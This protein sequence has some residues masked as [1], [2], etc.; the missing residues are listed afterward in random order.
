MEPPSADSPVPL[1]GNRSHPSLPPPDA[2]T[3]PP[4]PHPQPRTRYL[5]VRAAA[6]RRVLA[7]AIAAGVIFDIACHSG[8]TSIAGAAWVSVVAVVTLCSRRTR[9][10]TA[11]LFI[12]AAPAFGLILAVRASPWVTVPTA[13]A[14]GL[15]LTL[16]V[17]LGADNAGLTMTFPAL[18]SR[19][20]VAIGHFGL[21]PGF[22]RPRADIR[23]GGSTGNGAAIAKGLL[24]AAPVLL[25]VGLLL[26]EADPIFRSWFDLPS[27][28]H[29]LVLAAAGAWVAAGLARAASAERAAPA[30]PAAPSLG[31][32]EAALVLG[33]LCALYAVFVAAQ[34]V[35]LSGAGH[36]ILVTHGLTYAQYARSGFFELL[37]CAAITLPVL[38]GVRACVRAAHP[39]L[40]VLSALTVALTIGVVVVAVRRLQLYEA[41]FGLTMLRLACFA[42]AAWI[43]L[44]FVLLGLTIPRQ[45][46]P[47]A[48]FPATVFI[49]GLVLVGAWGASNPASLVAQ[50]NISRAEH[51]HRLDVSQ[52]AS[53]GPDATPSLLAGLKY[54]D[55]SQARQ[56]WAA[57]CAR[58]PGSHAGS[59]FNLARLRATEA[60]ARTCESR[61]TG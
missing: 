59:S 26:G 25:V 21:A 24:L 45:G 7:G 4:P 56:L 58:S 49:S 46:L 44:V 6:D 16:G 23:S 8:L 39:I 48:Y 60:M 33:G 3:W 11:R 30:L 20:T 51:G 53:L 2:T 36:R 29:Q 1:T 27:A 54:L 19:S 14:V 18:A 38:L 61:A 35:A 5:H 17:S 50:A 57:I 31:L 32:L 13:I 28:L 10:L 15:L 37:A 9:G 22:A 52:A 34:F 43:G 41:E 12:G 42:A 40:A 55:T 47:R